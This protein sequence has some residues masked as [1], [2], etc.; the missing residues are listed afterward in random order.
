MW[1]FKD[2]NRLA[3]ISAMVC[4]LM[5]P[6][7]VVGAIKLRNRRA[8]DGVLTANGLVCS[9]GLHDF[10][11]VEVADAATLRHEFVLQNI[12]RKTIRIIRKIA[13]CGC[14]TAD[15]TRETLQPNESLNVP[16]SVNWRNRNGAQSAQVTFQTDE[17]ADATITLRVTAT[18]SNPL[19][20][21]PRE[22]DFGELNPGLSVEKTFEISCDSCQSPL[23]VLEI[24]ASDPGVQIRRFGKTVVPLE[25]GAGTFGIKMLVGTNAGLEKQVVYVRTNQNEGA[26]IILLSARSGGAISAT[27]ASILFDYTRANAPGP[28]RIRVRAVGRA[29]QSDLKAEIIS[30]SG[31]P[32]FHLDSEATSHLGDTA[33][34]TLT[35]RCDGS[36]T[37]LGTASLHLNSGEDTLNIPIVV[38]G[39]LK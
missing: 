30:A 23:E 34:T 13:S 12:S 18:V 36:A 15:L 35:I 26:I 2:R 25:G 24:K 1:K 3:M 31:S 39:R 7:L 4:V 27:P 21:S 29:A 10:G 17:S 9:E 6:V 20:V 16:V 38:S 32:V 5:L 28:V 22:I 11:I 14:T 33:S 8:H 37:A 19:N